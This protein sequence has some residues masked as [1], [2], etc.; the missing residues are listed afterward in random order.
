MDR[1]VMTD[2]FFKFDCTAVRSALDLA[3]AEQAK[4]ALNQ[5]VDRVL[6]RA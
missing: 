6:Q 1:E 5:L 3:L 2:G 4:P